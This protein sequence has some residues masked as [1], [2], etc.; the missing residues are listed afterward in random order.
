MLKGKH[1][2]S[3]KNFGQKL[4]WSKKEF[5]QKKFWFEHYFGWYLFGWKQIL[6]G[7]EFWLKKA[8]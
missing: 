2:W 1:I 7:K 5:G 3:E 4:F 6:V 8:F